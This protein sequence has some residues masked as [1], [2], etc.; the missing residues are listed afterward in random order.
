MEDRLRHRV[1]G[2]D[3]ALAKVSESVRLSRA[4][5]ADP[6]R[7]IGS[8]MFLG[9]TGVGK[10]E[11]ARALAE[12]MFD[13]ENAMVR[14]DMS[15][16]MEKA[17]AQRLTGAPPGYVGY[18]EGGQLTEAIRRKPYA[19]LLFDEVEKGHPDVFN[20][21]LQLLE[22]GRL[23]DSHGKTTNFSNTLVIMTSNL[24]GADILDLSGRD[25]E[26]MERRVMGA[27]KGHF[28]PEFINR[29][30]ELV[31]FK[32]LGRDTL[33]LI[34][35]ILLRKLGKTLDPRQIKLELTEPAAQAVVEA[36]YE[37]RF[38]ARPLKRAVLRMIQRP[39]ANSLLQGEITDGAQLSVDLDTDGEGLVFRAKEGADATASGSD[40][41]DGAPADQPAG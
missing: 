25:D 1:V 19:V 40:G 34:L 38:G 14:L 7:P 37:P 39:L 2:Q 18:D 9:P 28:R 17:A 26:E 32:S 41:A 29:V 13:D 8:F 5:L 12:F 23:T 21:L 4:G 30:D 11:L 22:D 3:I 10:T 31:I 35:D 36:G 24:G 20:T 15:E 6:K 33:R 27:V 16:F